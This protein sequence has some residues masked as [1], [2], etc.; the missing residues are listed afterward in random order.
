MPN[1]V[2]LGRAVL[3]LIGSRVFVEGDDLVVLL[4]VRRQFHADFNTL[5]HFLGSLFV[6]GAHDNLAAAKCFFDA[7]GFF[8][9]GF[10]LGVVKIVGVSRSDEQGLLCVVKLGNEG[11]DSVG[12]IIVQRGVLSR[13]VFRDAEFSQLNVTLRDLGGHQFD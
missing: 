4:I 5:D 10:L 1:A 2:H 3:R 9:Q 12:A 7:V 8:D 6:T 11:F 13:V